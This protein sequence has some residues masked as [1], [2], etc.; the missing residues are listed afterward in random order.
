M[1]WKDRELKGSLTVEAACVM[2]MVLLAISVMIQQA[3]RI[4]DETVASMN[5]HEAIE[6][7]R[8][9]DGQKLQA[10]VEG[11]RSHTGRLM[12]FP[13]FSL[14]AERRGMRVCGKCSGG[15][16]S[17]EI[18]AEMFRPEIFLRKITLIEGLGGE[19]GD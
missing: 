19:N 7:G 14:T 10:A 5:L 3:G 17:G 1:K 4:H 12:F 8:H 6:K 15:K 9:G 13:S 18:E 2:A 16:W 11:G